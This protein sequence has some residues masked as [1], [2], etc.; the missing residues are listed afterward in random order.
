MSMSTFREPANVD[1]LA[2]MLTTFLEL[3]IHNQTL[4]QLNLGLPKYKYFF[5]VTLLTLIK[6]AVIQ[7]KYNNIMMYTME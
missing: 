6:N 3:G 1:C 7:Q 4:Y 5:S 2:L